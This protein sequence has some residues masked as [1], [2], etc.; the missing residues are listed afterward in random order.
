MDQ[1]VVTE[2]GMGNTTNQKAYPEDRLLAYN[3]EQLLACG[4]GTMHGPDFP[5]LPSPPMLMFDEIVKIDPEGGA[6]G[7]GVLEARMAVKPDLWFFG[8]HFKHDPV[9]PGCLGLDALWQLLGFYLGWRGAAGRGRALGAKDVKFSGQVLP[10][11]K[12]VIYRVEITRVKTAPLYMGMGDGEVIADG[13]RLYTVKGLK[14]GV[15]PLG[16]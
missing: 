5:A 13:K 2:A 4:D 1:D 14:V 11:N 15:M 7:K 6:S 8:C 9:M 16:S 3:Y 10:E 12:E